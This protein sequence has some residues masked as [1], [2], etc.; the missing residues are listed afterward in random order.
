MAPNKLLTLQ[1]S[2]VKWDH[3]PHIPC[4]SKLC[5]VLGLAIIQHLCIQQQAFIEHLLHTALGVGGGDK[6]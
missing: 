3:E 2:S 6:K 1:S 5:T 4:L